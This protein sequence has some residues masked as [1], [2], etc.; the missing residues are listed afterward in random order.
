[1][2]WLH[3][4]FALPSPLPR[5]EAKR[6][7]GTLSVAFTEMAYV[8][9]AHRGSAVFIC[10]HPELLSAAGEQVVCTY[11]PIGSLGRQPSPLLRLAERGSRGGR[12]YQNCQAEARGLALR[13]PDSKAVFCFSEGPGLTE[14]RK[15]WLEQ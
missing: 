4:F 8:P 5:T 7:Q 2:G 14:G 13:R 15:G 9:R 11:E 3:S 6:S 12:T 1:M 10:S